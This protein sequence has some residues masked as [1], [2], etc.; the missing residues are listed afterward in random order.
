VKA[1][2]A[3]LLGPS[4][5][6]AVVAGVLSGNPLAYGLAL[7]TAAPIVLV[8]FVLTAPTKPAPPSP[9]LVDLRRAYPSEAPTTVVRPRAPSLSPSSSSCG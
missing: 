2:A 7:G 6:W 3:I 9:P 8:G 1:T 4:F 5:V